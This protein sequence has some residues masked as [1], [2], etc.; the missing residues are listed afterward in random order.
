M[1][2]VPPEI[3]IDETLLAEVL[4]QLRD[5][6]RG[7]REAGAFLLA[8]ARGPREPADSSSEPHPRTVVRAAYYDG[9]DPT[10]LNGA[11]DFSAAGYTALTA[12][13]RAEHLR[14]VGDVHTHP[15]RTVRQSDTDAE[16]P[17]S[18]LPGHVA[19]IVPDYAR[20]HPRTTSFGAHLHLG[21]GR[22]RSFYGRD[23]AAVISVTRS[24]TIRAR[25]VRLFRS[26][27]T[28]WRKTP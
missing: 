17:M 27:F 12:L 8:A 1:K 19:L 25:V 2:G 3:V 7:T 21:G 10:A 11:I 24:P 18:V 5:R 6:G 16:H 13:C 23:V 15:A 22:W 4:R 26:V 20:G 28:P 9:L 14:V